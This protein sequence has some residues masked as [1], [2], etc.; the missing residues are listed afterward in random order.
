MPIINRSPEADD[1]V[2]EIASYIGQDNLEAAIRWVDVIDAKLRL[3]SEF[4]GLG[5]Q[6][7]ELAAGLRSLPGGELPHFL[8]A[9]RRRH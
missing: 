8:Q 7:D 1:D 4:S 5:T 9:R 6:R 2:V 3:L